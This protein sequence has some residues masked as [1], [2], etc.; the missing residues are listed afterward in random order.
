[1]S[2]QLFKPRSSGNDFTFSLIIK[3]GYLDCTLDLGKSEVQSIQIR[4]LKTC[5]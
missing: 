2:Y 4:R 3:V 5:E 1:M